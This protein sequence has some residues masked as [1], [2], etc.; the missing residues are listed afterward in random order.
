MEKLSLK[1]RITEGVGM[2]VAVGMEVAVGIG[3][4]V[5][6]TGVCVGRTRVVGV[7]GTVG[8]GTGAVGVV[9]PGVAAAICLK[10]D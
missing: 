1:G 7:G 9:T 5:G 10:G 8:E 6:G 2:V 4:G 3:V